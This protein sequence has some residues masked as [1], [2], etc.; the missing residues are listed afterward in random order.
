MYQISDI[1]ILIATMNRTNFDFL[2]AMFLFSDFRHFKLVIINQTSENNL[3]LSDNEQ[4]KVYNQLEY[5]LSK[6]RNLALQK[7][8]EALVVF[9]DDDVV[10]QQNFEIKLLQAF[11]LHLLHDGF[12]FKF[13]TGNGYLAKKYPKHFEDKLTNL[14]ILNTASVELAFK[15]VSLQKAKLQF[16][17]NFGLGAAF[18][19]GEEAI[20]VSDAIKKGL[21]IG[22]FPEILVA[23]IHAST[24][25]KMDKYSLYYLQSAL[26][27]R[28]FPKMYLFWI[29][30]KL[31][32]DLK[33]NK[34]QFKTVLKL[35][36]QACNG[37]KAYV[38]YTK[39]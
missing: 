17:I 4:I 8:S 2:K 33:Q 16:D 39:M 20:F 35:F 32:F 38:N 31:F 12:R 13:L 24:G 21:K 23:H 34:I 37:K 9:T 7:A 10:F 26:L 30:L 11:N 15:R 3:L 36:I 6:S 29:F 28:I 25:N 22:F 27:Y 14:E 19:M 1:E 18:P 5:G